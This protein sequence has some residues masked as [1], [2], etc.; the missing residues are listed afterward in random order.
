MLRPFDGLVTSLQMG[1]SCS[2]QMFMTRITKRK[3]AALVG[4][5]PTKGKVVEAKTDKAWQS[6]EKAVQTGA[7]ATD[8]LLIACV[9]AEILLEQKHLNMLSIALS[10]SLNM[11]RKHSQNSRDGSSFVGI[12][13][14]HNSL[15]Y[16]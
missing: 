5:H 12:L 14:R 10:A 13:C 16:R 6:L 2:L 3:A 15:K 8:L 4:S 1:I 9:L 7:S 11:I